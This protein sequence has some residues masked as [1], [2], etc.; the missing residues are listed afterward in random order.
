[1]N[2]AFAAPRRSHATAAHVER[3]A[4]TPS[5][6]GT[7]IDANGTIYLSDVD[8]RR[9]L[10]ISAD[11]KIT[12]LIADPRLAWVDAMWIDDDGNLLMPAAQINR[13]AGLNGGVDAVE[14]PITLYRLKIGQ[15]GVRR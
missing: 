6:G 11:G 12:T 3:F 1:M 7:A 15:K 4:D 14:K 8:A 5:T 2:L 10:T 9:I 13:I